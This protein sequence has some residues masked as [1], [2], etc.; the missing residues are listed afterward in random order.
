MS[1]DGGDVASDSPA[2][3]D[4]RDALDAAPDELGD[5]LDA[6]DAADS[7]DATDATDAT[8]S[9]D[10]SDAVDATDSSDAS[11]AEAGVACEAGATGLSGAPGTWQQFGEHLGNSANTPFLWPALTLLPDDRPVVSWYEGTAIQTRIWEVT[12]CG[13]RWID[14]GPITGDSPSL[15]VDAQ[16]APILAFDAYAAKPS[17]VSVMRFDGSKFVPLGAPLPSTDHGV[18]RAVTAPSLAAG[19]NGDLVLAWVDF[20]SSSSSTI[21]A[22]RWSGTA[23]V[24]MT[25]SKGALG[26]AASGSPSGPSLVMTPDGA[27]LASWLTL[28]HAT[29]V[30]R[31]VSGTTWTSVGTPPSGA[32]G[33]GENN[34]PLLAVG[35]TG[36]INLAWKDRTAPSTYHTFAAQYDGT[37]W[38]ALGGALATAGSASGDYT[39]AMDATDAPVIINSEYLTPQPGNKG[40][41]YRW[42]GTSWESPAPV[43]PGPSGGGVSAPRLAIDHH[44]RW[45]AAWLEY[46]NAGGTTVVVARWQP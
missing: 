21:Q 14:P 18:A 17:H 8:D 31:F 12:A 45:V 32:V 29:A 2:D 39:L 24:A 44:G 9:A 33:G 11:D 10:S 30:A 28:G 4:E 6:A 5:Q 37:A 43:L 46:S 1:P 40:F 38:K 15:T 22:A 3:T 36:V 35:K 25:D 41:N 7:N 19:A 42:N 13:G 27:V 23:W 20:P 34:G 26:I 16:G